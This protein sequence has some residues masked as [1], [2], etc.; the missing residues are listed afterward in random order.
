[1]PI[2]RAAAPVPGTCEIVPWSGHL[3]LPLF[4]SRSILHTFMQINCIAQTKLYCALLL[5]D[6][7]WF[8]WFV[9]VPSVVRGLVVVWLFAFLPS[10]YFVSSLTFALASDLVLRLNERSKSV[11]ALPAITKRSNAER[12]R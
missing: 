7:N 9:C 1:M 6:L 5:Q 10:L 11:L 12:T 4:W 8:V 3:E 2:A